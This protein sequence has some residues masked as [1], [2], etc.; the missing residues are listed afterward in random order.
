MQGN[1]G[2]CFPCLIRRASLAHVGWDDHAYAYNVF[3]PDDLQTLLRR[4][5]RR[6]ADL[7]AVVLGAFAERP[8][9]D[10]LRNG[11]LPRDERRA[12]VEVWRRGLGELRRWLS[13]GTPAE[14]ADLLPRRTEVTS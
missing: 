8:D 5:S 3:D 1:C 12:F 14:L 2:Y 7:R 6:G 9:H 13:T 4:R 10:A 11:P